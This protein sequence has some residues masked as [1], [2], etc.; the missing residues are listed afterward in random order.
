MAR[1][2][3]NYQSASDYYRDVGEEAQLKAMKDCGLIDDDVDPEDITYFAREPKFDPYARNMHADYGFTYNDPD[4]DIITFPN[5]ESF[6]IL[7]VAGDSNFWDEY[8]KI[9][10]EKE[11]E[12]I[13]TNITKERS[14]EHMDEN[15]KK[16]MDSSVNMFNQKVSEINGA[17]NAVISG[18]LDRNS[19]SG[20]RTIIAN[21]EN[22]I[23]ASNPALAYNTIDKLAANGK[24]RQAGI[25]MVKMR[26]ERIFNEGFNSLAEYEKAKG[27]GTGSL[28]EI[29]DPGRA[30]PVGQ[31]SAIVPGVNGGGMQI[32]PNAQVVD[33]NITAAT[34][35]I[36]PNPVTPVAAVQT[37]SNIQEVQTPKPLTIGGTQP[38]QPQVATQTQQKGKLPAGVPPIAKT[39]M[40]QVNT[41]E[42]QK[43]A[44]E[45]LAKQKAA[46]VQTTTAADQISQATIQMTQ[47]PVQPVIMEQQ[48]PIAST[49]V[50]EQPTYT[51]TSDIKNSVWDRES[52]KDIDSQIDLLK[53]N[54]YIAEAQNKKSFRGVAMSK[55][56]E[57]RKELDT[58]RLATARMSYRKLERDLAICVLDSGIPEDKIDTLMELFNAIGV[59]E[60]FAL[61]VEQVAMERSETNMPMR[62]RLEAKHNPY[63]IFG[64][65]STLYERTEPVLSQEANRLMEVSKPEQFVFAS[66]KKSQVLDLLDYINKNGVFVYFNNDETRV[67]YSELANSCLYNNFNTRSFEN[68]KSIIYYM[69]S[70]LEIKDTL[71]REYYISTFGDVPENDKNSGGRQIMTQNNNLRP[72]FGAN[73]VPGM[74]TQPTQATQPATTTVQP[75][76]T[77]QVPNQPVVA[78]PTI[79]QPGTGTQVTP[80]NPMMTGAAIQQPTQV[81]Q[82]VSPQIVNPQ[83]QVSTP[84]A[85]SNPQ[86]ITMQGVSTTQGAQMY[87][88]VQP[89]VP[90][91]TPSMVQP[92]QN[93]V[94]QPTQMVQPQVAQQYVQPGQVQMMPQ[95]PNNYQATV[96]YQPQQQMIAAPTQGVYVPQTYNYTQ[97]VVAQPQLANT[98]IL[99]NN[100]TLGGNQMM[101][102]GMNMMNQM[103]AQTQQGMM[104]YNPMMNQ[105]QMGMGMVQ[106][107]IPQAPMMPNMMNQMNMGMN[108]M[109]NGASAY[110]TVYNRQYP[111]MAPTQSLMMNNQFGVRT[112]MMNQMNPMA[113]TNPMMGGM[114]NQNPMMQNPMMN[115]MNMMGNMNMMARQNPMMMPQTPMMHTNPMMMNQMGMNMMNNQMPGM[116]PMMNHTMPTMT[117]PMMNTAMNMNMGMNPMMNTQMGMMNQNPMMNNQ[118]YA[119]QFLNGLTRPN[120]MMNGNMM[121]YNAM[122]QPMGMPNPMMN[123]MGMMNTQMNPMM[124]GY[125]NNQMM[126]NGYGMNGM[127]F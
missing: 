101:Y 92:A 78:A 103:G 106:P 93:T 30:I 29:A 118:M 76:Q 117:N 32:I 70:I 40:G 109:M 28:L 90:V 54:G 7:D 14:A 108:P 85:P 110:P 126:Y 97:P 74:I 39:L 87:G 11:Q 113:Q 18:G 3:F 23:K 94:V 27:I 81:Q 15:M 8:E 46:Q 4:D 48:P 122:N 102:N 25:D 36:N 79:P 63:D 65:V 116:N 17:A 37:A 120:P 84:L 67:A 16:L 31:N 44:D 82:V 124:G 6:N 45:Y 104:G 20:R 5:G 99:N 107:S 10:E 58:P 35:T 119:N 75:T 96:N 88:G 125:P 34:P 72:T 68:W 60:S 98:N 86:P 62:G 112:P 49:P 105:Q 57:A 22:E 89:T 21:I 127:G 26:A 12:E 50:V 73:T 24:P 121:G 61:A 55:L 33:G 115:Q 56:V 100:N 19:T 2:V 51:E 64:H 41:A 95:A 52:I 111:V 66:I 123:Q 38:I 42:L 9:I 47:P 1:E 43:Q 80:Q 59:G 91:G 71:L 69:V 13:T 77:Q 114:M 53:K 83:V